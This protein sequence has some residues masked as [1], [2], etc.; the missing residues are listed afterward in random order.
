MPE[1]FPTP[2]QAVIFRNWEMV[3]KERLAKVLETDVDNIAE[4]AKRMGL[5]K[6]G[7]TK[8]WSE[9]GY[10]TIIRANWHLLPYEQLLTILDWSEEKL[11]YVLKEEDFLD[12][13]LGRGKPECEKVIY[14]PLTKEE[15]EKTKNIKEIIK[16][17]ATCNDEIMPFDF[18]NKKETQVQSLQAKS[19][20]IVLDDN[21]T[22][23][24]KTDDDI[25][26]LIA[27]RFADSMKKMWGIDLNSQGYKKIVLSLDKTKNE[28]YHTITVQ[29]E[30]LNVCAGGSA[31]ILRA[32][33]RI[34][35]IS[36]GAGGPYFDEGHTER[37]PRFETRFIYSFCSLYEGAFDVDSNTY[38]PDS[39]LEEYAKIGINGIWLQAVLYR[40]TKFEFAPSLS[41]GWEKRQENLRKFVNRA[42]SYGIKIYLYLNE[43]RTMPLSFFEK[44]PDMKGAVSGQFACMCLS[45]KKTQN[46]LSNSVEALCRAVPGLGGFLTITMSENLT[47]CKSRK[48]D[49]SCPYCTQKASWELVSFVINLM[50]KGARRVDSEVKFFAWDWGWSQSLGFEDGD[51]KKCIESLPPSVSI[52]CEREKQIPFVRGGIEGE[53]DEYSL[54]I[55]GLSPKSLTNWNYAKNAGHDIAVKLQINNSWECSTVPYL[56]VFKTLTN[57]M[58]S[59]ISINS[60][61][62]MLSWTLGGYPSPNIKLV[63][64]AFFIENGNKKV[65]Y[66]NCLKMMFGQDSSVVKNATDI[67]CEA[68]SNFPFCVEVLYFGP[69]NGGVANPLYH[70]PTGHQA[71]MTCFAYD[72]LTRW[73]ANYPEEVLEE[74]FRLMSNG[75]KEGMGLI[76]SMQGDF[77]DVCYVAYTLFLS[78]YNQIRYVRL[79]N[80][81]LQ[82]EEKG[83][84]DEILNIIESENKMAQEVYNIMCRQPSIGYEAANH[85]YFSRQSLLEKMV[86]CNWLKE[87]YNS[88]KECLK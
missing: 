12:V 8:L 88:Q 70:K 3:S 66:D 73:R 29:K 63:S 83:V 37:V 7:D 78:G 77:K 22:I 30:C 62:L 28:E 6:Q 16:K 40:V 81:Y 24:N 67:F 85:Y 71:T 49:V 57:I 47:H 25:V 87:Y 9:K 75:W 43:P 45:S 1:Y 74:Q 55:E 20:Q 51:V 64:E 26:T 18:W 54:S 32:L 21:W 11:A 72:D 10:I 15:K 38:C 86:N 27:K 34:E 82:K 59:L 17:V 36:R 52:L 31:G 35:D 13:K 19:G 79:R 44:Y 48:V 61:H 65:D 2:M 84:K 69:Q 76:D 23:E 56:P 14:H 42:K 39:L 33:Y 41:E 53:V 5:G 4:E 46:Y 80:R 50:E 58:E 60:K 68:F